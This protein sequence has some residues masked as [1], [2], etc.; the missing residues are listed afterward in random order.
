VIACGLRLRE[1]ALPGDERERAGGG[2]VKVVGYVRVSTDEQGRSGLGLKAQRAAIDAECERRGWELLGIEQDVASGRSR[3]RR[4]GL[5]RAV[6]AC[7]R[8]DAQ[9]IVA[10]KLDRLSR[11]V[12]DAGQLLDAA[13]RGGW[14]VVALDFGLDLSTP[15]GRL[16]ANV[17]ASVGQ[18]EREAIGERTRAALAAKRAE[19]WR[20]PNP[21][22]PDDVRARVAE[23]HRRG[24][25]GRAI[26]DRLNADRVPALGSRWHLRTIQRL[27]HTA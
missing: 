7:R 25:S 17:L 3:K 20:H 19:G 1:R 23:L 24:L 9:A 5:E 15:Q 10:A 13:Q 11:S 27:L 8:G 4:P 21:R 2:A 16:V 6:A 18:W 12:V 26:A 22:V 14:N